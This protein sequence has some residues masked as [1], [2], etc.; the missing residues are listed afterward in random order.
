MSLRHLSAYSP[1]D[2]SCRPGRLNLMLPRYKKVTRREFLKVSFTAAGAL[3]VG[4]FLDS[5]AS[6]TSIP[7]NVSTLSPTATDIPLPISDSPFQPNAFIRI[8][9]DGKI[10]FTIHRSEMGQ[11]VRTS[12]AMILA[13]ELEVKW[14]AV[15]VEQMDVN[16]KLNQ[17]TS[18]S[19]SVTDNYPPL[20]DAGAKANNILV[21]PPAQFWAV[22]VEEC[23]AAQGEVSH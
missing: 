16:S 11:G 15:H 13:E 12:L 2:S 8:D 14:E 20:R 21:S 18:G 4:T 23:T 7:I 1:R 6:P 19:G 5:C 22:P 10:T 17:T 9:P 3:L